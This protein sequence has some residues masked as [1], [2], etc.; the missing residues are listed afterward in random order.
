M[1]QIRRQ[2]VVP[3]FGR[4]VGEPVAIVACRVVDQHANRPVRGARLGDR[5]AQRGDVAHVAAGVPH[6]GAFR[7]RVQACDE[8]RRRR[9]VDVHEC[10]AAPLAEKV[11][12][13]RGAEARRAAGYE[14]AASGEIGIDRAVFHGHFGGGGNAT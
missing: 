9:V 5:V 1:P 3:E 10:D 4:Q 13:E 7:Q 2:V 6:H 8:R 14:H 12:D 11:F